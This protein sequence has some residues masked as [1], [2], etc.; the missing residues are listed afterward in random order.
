MRFVAL[1]LAGGVLGFL[2]ARWLFPLVLER[3]V[4]FLAVPILLL[5]TLLFARALRRRGAGS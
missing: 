4:L 5:A 2:F 1:A 3:N